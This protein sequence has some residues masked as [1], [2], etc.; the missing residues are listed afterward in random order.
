MANGPGLT[1]NVGDGLDPVDPD[2]VQRAFAGDDTALDHTVEAYPQLL[3]LLTGESV[4]G[5]VDPGFGT[6]RVNIETALRQNLRDAR[7]KMPE[8]RVGVLV[9]K[10]GNQMGN[11]LRRC[12][13]I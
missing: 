6:H 12:E 5:Q 10:S 1:P 3:F 4:G 11:V 8:T 2:F 7:R 13:R 9:Q